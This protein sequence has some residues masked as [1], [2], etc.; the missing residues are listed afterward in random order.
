MIQKIIKDA[1]TESDNET[2][3]VF[4]IIV[5]LIFIFAMS[6]AAYIV[7]IQHSPTFTFMDFCGGIALLI[8]PTAALFHFKKDSN[9]SN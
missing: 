4:R 7:F 1:L 9:A 8:A 6:L 3:D 2:F 5:V